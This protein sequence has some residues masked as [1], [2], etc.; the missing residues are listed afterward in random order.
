MNADHSFSTQAVSMTAYHGTNS[1]FEEF[2]LDFFGCTDDGYYGK[3]FYFTQSPE[4]ASEYG[5][6]VIE[7]QL[8]LHN[9]F[10]LPSSGCCGHP[11]LHD[12]RDLLANLKGVPPTLR[13]NR[14][15]PSGYELQSRLRPN[16]YNP[17]EDKQW[18]YVNPKPHLFGTD[19]EI[20]GEEKENRLDAIVSF[21]DQLAGQS[22]DFGWTQCVLKEIGRDGL[23]DILLDNSYDSILVTDPDFGRVEVVVLKS[24]QI[25]ILSS[26]TNIQPAYA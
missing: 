3:G 15:L 7:A 2:S 8:S 6:I 16:P 25:K 9:P 21:N 13:T 5:H 4:T 12:V 14:Q 11:C 1:H 10:T 19:L 23:G 17:Q 22:Y 24:S 18:F 26:T 20:Y